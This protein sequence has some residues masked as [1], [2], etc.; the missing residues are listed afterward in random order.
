MRTRHLL[1]VSFGSSP[2]DSRCGF[3]L[4]ALVSHRAW[5][6]FWQVQLV[7]NDVFK[8]DARRLS[9]FKTNR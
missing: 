7:V 8:M 1:D 2:F 5:E 6:S 9:I 3:A 4:D